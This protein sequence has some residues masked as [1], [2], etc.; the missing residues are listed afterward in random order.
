[1]KLIGQVCMYN[2]ATKGNLERCLINLSRYCDEI[3]I[4][5]D[6]S[7]DDSVEIALRYTPHIIR[8][9]INNQI[10]ELAH[11]QLILEKSLELGATHLFWLDCDEVVERIGTEGGLRQLCEEWPAGVD[12]FSFRELNLWRSKRWIRT[13]SLFAVGRFVRLWKVVPGIRFLVEP[14]VH[15]RLY[16]S[17]INTVREAPFGVI[18]YGFCE[19]N[20]MLVKIGAH[21]WNKK[22]WMVRTTGNWILNETE[23]SCYYAPDEMFPQECIPV[24]DWPQPMPRAID[25]MLTYAELLREEG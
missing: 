11:K 7:T 1:M 12:A 21:I 20:K 4:Y 22:D 5:D 10:Q 3:V 25:S 9:E 2:E 15:R 8:G 13:D 19:Y 16:P 18:H 17:T 14:G 24:G 6:A 23:C